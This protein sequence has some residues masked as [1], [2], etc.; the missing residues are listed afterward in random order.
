MVEEALACL[1]KADTFTAVEFLNQ[2]PDPAA[3]AA[4]YSALLKRLYWEKRDVNA[5]LGLGRAGIQF[6]SDKAEAAASCRYMDQAY[7]LRSAAKQLSYNLASYTWPGWNE[8]DLML[9]PPQIAA[10]LDAARQ[11]LRLALEL[12]KGD[13]PLSRA[14]W[15]LGG[16][17]LSAGAYA[18][19]E[20]HYSRAE[21][22]A[23]RAGEKSEGA[24]A[25][26]FCMLAYWLPDTGNEARRKHYEEARD[27]LGGFENGP[28]FLE[29]LDNAKIV[30]VD[31]G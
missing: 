9:E 24:L 26:A 6:C 10:G 7:K 11:N 29:Q 15:M 16:H 1:E 8:P 30:F 22:Y 19:A 14:Y 12:D 31:A 20:A 13:L 28:H 4:A 21:M 5:V 27:R 3:V 18:E 17:L 2:Q 23:K 25:H